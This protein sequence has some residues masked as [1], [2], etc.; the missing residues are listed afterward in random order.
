[1]AKTTEATETKTRKRRTALEV[2]MDQKKEHAAA[3]AAIKAK[4]EQL[5]N[6]LVAAEKAEADFIDKA[7]AALGV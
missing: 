4:I 7:R 3:V 1:M 2:F 5:Q 6:D